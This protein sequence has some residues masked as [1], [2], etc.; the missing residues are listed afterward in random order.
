MPIF[1][2]RR[3]TELDDVSVMTEA[4]KERTL[5]SLALRRTEIDRELEAL[6]R[7]Y[8]RL[9]RNPKIAKRK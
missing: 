3:Y 9:S 7:R 1:S 2:K 8:A 5:S 4:E 6:M